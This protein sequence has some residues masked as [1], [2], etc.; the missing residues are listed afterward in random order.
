VALARRTGRM[1]EPVIRQQLAD[2]VLTLE[3]LRFNQL[4]MLTA[5][6]HDGTPGPEASIGKLFWA[7]WHRRLGEIGMAV[8]G[9]SA[10]VAGPDAAVGHGPAAKDYPLD[11][12]QRTFLYSRAHTIYGGSNEVQRNILAER[13]LGLPR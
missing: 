11:A 2:A 4:R 1:D 10:M 7:S 8:R 3:V 9:A 6:T 12:L 5:L 13:V